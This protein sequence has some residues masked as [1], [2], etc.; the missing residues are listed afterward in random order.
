MNA[1][2][3]AYQDEERADIFEQVADSLHRKS[4]E[5]RQVTHAA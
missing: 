3:S 2:A 5:G 1:V 4:F